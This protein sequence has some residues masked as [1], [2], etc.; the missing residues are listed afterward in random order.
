GHKRVAVHDPAADAGHDD[1]DRTRP[2]SLGVED[3]GLGRVVGVAVVVADDLIP[4]VVALALD[5]Y[6]VERVDLVAVAGP[7]GHGVAGSPGLGYAG[8]PARPH[9]HPADLVRV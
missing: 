6:V 2:R 7:V 4:V 3:R 8:A 5:A 9:Q 1:V